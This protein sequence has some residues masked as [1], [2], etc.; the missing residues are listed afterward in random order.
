MASISLRGYNKQIEQLVEEGRQDEAISHCQ[1][2][3]KFFPK[4]VDTYRLLGK[5]Y[6]ESQQFGDA[7]DI[8]QRVLSAVP[9]DFVAHVGMSI[10]REDEANLDAAIWHMERAF[11]VQSSNSAIQEELR[12]LYGKRDDAEPAKIRMTRG[13]LARMYAHGHLYA[14]SISELRIALSKD[15]QRLD[16]QTMLARMYYLDRQRV[17]ATKIASRLL[18]KLPYCLEANIIIS[19]VFE[20]TNR[21]AEAKDYRKRTQEL[22]PYRTYMSENAPSPDEVPDG[23]VM[24]VFDDWEPS[25]G[26]ITAP[27]SPTWAATLGVDDSSASA[28]EDRAP[29]WLEAGDEDDDS[30]V[31]LQANLDRA[32]VIF[33]SDASPS[34]SEQDAEGEA[35]LIPD[36]IQ[37]AGWMQSEDDLEDLDGS[38][39]GESSDVPPAQADEGEIP[40][41]LQSIGSDREDQAGLA[42]SSA[43]SNWL[44]ELELEDSD[45]VEQGQAEPE[46]DPASGVDN[47]LPDWVQEL[48][49]DNVPTAPQIITESMEYL[50]DAGQ[51][52]A[53]E[54]PD[55]TPQH[56]ASTSEA[57]PDWLDS[58]DESETDSLIKPA[59]ETQPPDDSPSPDW[60]KQIETDQPKASESSDTSDFPVEAEIPEWLQQAAPAD[61][62][63]PVSELET[64]PDENQL[65]AWLDDLDGED[66][67]RRESLPAAHIAAE[68]NAPPGNQEVQMSEHPE[69]PIEDDEDSEKEGPEVPDWLQSLVNEEPD[70][71][72]DIPEHVTASIVPDWVK[73]IDESETEGGDVENEPATGDDSDTV[74]LGM[75]AGG[76]DLDLAISRA[77]A[78]E[79]ELTEETDEP[80]PIND[81]PVESA[82]LPDWIGEMA[83]EPE[84][85]VP[86]GATESSILNWL[87]GLNEETG[88]LKPISE[89]EDEDDP[90]DEA[91]TSWLGELAAPDISLAPGEA[92]AEGASESHE[93]IADSLMLDD[94][95]MESLDLG[96]LLNAADSVD[97]DSTEIG[98]REVSSEAASTTAQTAAEDVS[99]ETTEETEEEMAENEVP[100]FDDDDAALA[101]LE[102]LAAKQGASEE[103]L[104]T[105]P[106]ERND[107]VPD[108]LQDMA[109]VVEDE[110]DDD[111]P[112]AVEAQ[113]SETA[114]AP[115]EVN[116]AAA[117][118]LISSRA[119][120]GLA[121]AD[122]P[123]AEE[124]APAPEMS[125]TGSGAQ[126]DAEVEEDDDQALAWL[127][128]LA[129]KQGADEA[130]LLTEPDDRAEEVPDW[131]REM[132]E[133]PAQEAASDAVAELASDESGEEVGVVAE[134]AEDWLSSLADDS[135]DADD[136]A[137]DEGDAVPSEAATSEDDMPSWLTESA[138]SFINDADTETELADFPGGAEPDDPAESE[139]EL[140]AS[141]DIPDW[142]KSA[143][144]EATAESESTDEVEDEPA[145]PD[146]ISQAG[147]D[148]V[149]DHLEPASDDEVLAAPDWLQEIAESPTDAPVEEEAV[150]PASM[151]MPEMEIVEPSEPV[152]LEPEP[153]SESEPEPEPVLEIETEPEQEPEPEPELELEAEPE[154]EPEPELELEAEPEP[155]PEPEPEL[156]LEAEPEPEPE[157]ELEAEPELEPEP[158]LEIEA[159]PEPEPEPE[160]ELELEAEAEP[161]LMTP[162]L[163]AAR[164]ALAA[165]QI[166]DAIGHYDTAIQASEG[167]ETVIAELFEAVSERHPV[168]VGLWQTLGDAYL[169]DDQI[170]EA[171]DAYTKAE[172]LIR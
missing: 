126:A 98:Y 132:A 151:N 81:E 128:N 104:L 136:T 131:L 35:G 28:G 120:L 55:E 76:L 1:H 154:L 88:E 168:D 99:M 27:G 16:L 112:E 2:I 142:L 46:Q 43:S 143:S 66:H 134:E 61:T 109:D 20:E 41:W 77:E 14:Q 48:E 33:A 103:E 123:E 138:V 17:N 139:A 149:E 21:A 80:D 118:T 164:D 135:D 144:E 40:E 172:D 160:Q 163:G 117:E 89:E 147:E 93:E 32:G 59:S 83:P 15:P 96:E 110:P 121:G 130:E 115:E 94:D 42:F 18:Q 116:L 45:P 69:T 169:R 166:G 63:S 156:E 161:A 53:P 62:P 165:G 150:L 87:E 75:S 74:E 49:G 6:L 82:D 107:D 10:I 129:A 148:A 159:E 44:D 86:A 30:F 70:A 95:E 153:E 58:V 84:Q 125:E 145:V 65:P 85:E 167:L 50:A 3:L 36:F 140:V 71:Q 37:D 4:H 141:E 100:D 29:S 91:I 90:D 97:T 9:D 170:Q 155:E 54:T 13:A 108:W 60:V 133:E 146:W 152:D 25:A 26:G 105:E 119:D 124:A 78:A 23:A 106:E 11:D 113:A 157:L 127:E 92:A 57:V 101:W 114:E 67:E 51:Q 19:E 47:D 122:V 79:G 162:A 64:E 111:Q 12:R 38:T 52:D 68:D 39:S 73:Q 31:D 171:L 8:F 72:L 7:A 56:T 137:D 24:L 102:S 34:I 22:D 158:E 5:S